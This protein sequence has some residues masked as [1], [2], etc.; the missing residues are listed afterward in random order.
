MFK[1]FLDNYIIPDIKAAYKY[2]SVQFGILTVVWVSIPTNWQ[3][4]VANFVHL[5][6]ANTIT[7]VLAI[8]TLVGRFL[9]QKGLDK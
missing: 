1:T 6:D 5:G 3:E 8:C 7:A 9:A 2:L 4:A